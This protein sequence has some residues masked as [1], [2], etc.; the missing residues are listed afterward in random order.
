MEAIGATAPGTA[1]AIGC[2]WM[3]FSIAKDVT[4]A[5]QTAN[6]EERIVGA[7]EA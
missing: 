6:M 2:D 7:N 3:Q 1:S 4:V 5:I